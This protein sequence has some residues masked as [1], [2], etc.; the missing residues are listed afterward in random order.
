[1]DRVSVQNPG[2][3]WL[4]DLKVADGKD[5]VEG[6]I[7]YISADNE[8]SPV[9]DADAAGQGVKVLC[10]ETK[11]SADLDKT[12]ERKASFLKMG[13]VRTNYYDTNNKPTAGNAVYVDDNGKL[14]SVSLNTTYAGD[15]IQGEL[16]ENIVV[17][18]VLVNA[19]P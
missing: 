12:P 4:L 5:A 17:S 18:L 7:Y 10:L 2:S 9:T 3:A 11:S 15:C 19:G 1:M 13:V 16:S 6:K 8:A 14:T